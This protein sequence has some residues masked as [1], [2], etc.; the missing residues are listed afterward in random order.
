M[1]E[2]EVRRDPIRSPGHQRPQ[3]FLVTALPRAEEEVLG[4]GG[5]EQVRRQDEVQPLLLHHARHHGHE[6]DPGIDLEP[7]GL[8]QPGLAFGLAREII[9]FVVRLDV[10]VGARIPYLVVDAVHDA[11]EPVLESDERVVETEA[12]R[13]RAEL[14]GMSGT[15]RRG[16]VR[17]DEPPFQD[18]DLAVPF[19]P[20]EVEQVIGQAD[21][22]QNIERDVALITGVVDREDGRDGVVVALAG[23]ECSQVDWRPRRVPIVGMQQH[24][25]R[26]DLRKRLESRETEEREAAVVVREVAAC[27]PVDAGPVEVLFVLDEER[28]RAAAGE[29][30]GLEIGLVEPCLFD[31]ARDRD[32]ER[33]STGR[34]VRKTLGDG[35]VE[36]QKGYARNAGFALVVRHPA[37][38][39]G[40]PAGLGE[41][42][43]FGDEVNHGI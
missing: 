30:V 36:R 14:V 4:I 42:P 38:G 18:V 27:I 13:S 34:H 9:P 32:G 35:A 24:G 6:R 7:T 1:R 5:A 20:I 16:H 29:P 43:V 40:Q 15:D 17:E 22:C 23:Q 21:I 19:H 37:S 31:A 28:A 12:A 2:V 41:R 25:T 10:G 26:G 11:D 33:L 3:R 39:I 8:L